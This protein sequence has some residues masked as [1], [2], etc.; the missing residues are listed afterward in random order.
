MSELNDKLKEIQEQLRKLCE[1]YNIY[2]SCR[3]VSDYEDT[4]AEIN[5]DIWYPS[6]G[7]C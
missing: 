2:F 5:I 6:R 3:M 1:E 4:P 7:D